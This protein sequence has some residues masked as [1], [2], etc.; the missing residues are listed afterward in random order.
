MLPIP[1]VISQNPVP[2]EFK[3]AISSTFTKGSI[4][5]ATT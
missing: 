4:N 2:M 5:P 3:S 1:E